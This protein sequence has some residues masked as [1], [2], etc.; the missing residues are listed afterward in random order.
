MKIMSFDSESDANVGIKQAYIN[1]VKDM[2]AQRK[3]IRNGTPP[4]AT[5]SGLTPSQISRL[6]VC[7]YKDHVL[8]PTKGLTTS[9]VTVIKAYDHEEWYCP[10]I[11]EKY[12]K[13]VVKFTIIDRPADWV[14][15][16]PPT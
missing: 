1:Y 12:Q 6:K 13:D 9:L 10:L 11:A 7:G 4:I 15:P 16:L 14:Q 8:A 5:L 3:P 2:F